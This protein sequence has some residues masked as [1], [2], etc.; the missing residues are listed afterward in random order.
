[1]DRAQVIERKPIRSPLPRN[2]GQRRNRKGPRAGVV[3]TLECAVM[4]LRRRHGATK[5][6]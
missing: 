3:A 1:M 5:V 4:A 2:C 6:I